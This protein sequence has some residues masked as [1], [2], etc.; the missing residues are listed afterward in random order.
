MLINTFSSSKSMAELKRPQK[1]PTGGA[2]LDPNSQ[3]PATLSVG[4]E[5]TSLEYSSKSQHSLGIKS[6]L[7]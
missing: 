6:E 7:V 2:L 3:R 1:S 5:G 4:I